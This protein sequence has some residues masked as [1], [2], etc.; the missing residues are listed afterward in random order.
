MGCALGAIAAD[1]GVGLEAFDRPFDRP[2]VVPAEQR[3]QYGSQ[4]AE[5]RP[6]GDDAP[7]EVDVELAAPWSEG[8][9]ALAGEIADD[10]D[11]ELARALQPHDLRAGLEVVGQLALE[12][13]L[14]DAPDRGL[15]IGVDL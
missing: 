4:V 8:P 5:Q 10:L 15:A 11:L 9:D 2:A 1:A 3:A 7:V 6:V 12:L 13:L 14:R